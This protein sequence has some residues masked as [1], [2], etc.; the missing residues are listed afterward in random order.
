[1][2]V[3]LERAL[4]R[5]AAKKGLSKERKDAYVYGTLRKTGWKPER[6]KKMNDP[7]ETIQFQ[8]GK[9]Y[10][11]W[12][13]PIG[14]SMPSTAE[15]VQA[16]ERPKVPFWKR[17]LGLKSASLAHVRLPAP[18]KYESSAKLV[19][20]SLI[21]TALD[22]VIKF[23][24]EDDQDQRR[25]FPWLTAGAAA[26][27]GAG[28]LLAHQAIRSS[29]GYAKN[30]LGARAG[31]GLARSGLGA[32][33]SAG[34]SLG[35]KAGGLAGKGVNILG[36]ILKK[37]RRFESN[38]KPI[39]FKASIVGPWV[40]SKGHE[41]KI[42]QLEFPA[43]LSP[44]AALKFPLPKLMRYMNK[45]NLMQQVFSRKQERLVELNSKLDEIQL[46]TA[47]GI[48]IGAGATLGAAGA[49]YGGYKAVSVLKEH[50]RKMR[51]W[52]KNAGDEDF[53]PLA[54]DLVID[55][56][57]AMYPTDHP[58]VQG[59]NI[60]ALKSRLKEIQFRED[61]S[62][63]TWKGAAEVGGAAA[64]GYGGYRGIKALQPTARFIE[65]KSAARTAVEREVTKM[66]KR[67]GPIRWG[68]TG[69]LYKRAG[70]AFY[71]GARHARL[72]AK[73]DDV[74]QLSVR[75]SHVGE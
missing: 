59:G 55:R 11:P 64:V 30:L 44:A 58:R 1:M 72:S 6:E 60:T 31:Y 32:A 73:L 65:G 69:Q 40:G 5:Q 48:A 3:K 52:K 57:G 62:G 13:R 41:S 20:L 43:G 53:L 75:K 7:S 10:K 17:A 54:K 16:I 36:D 39:E 35:Y 70:T 33:S 26:G 14:Q 2:P 68:E 19:R 22:S 37:F 42:D 15:M 67:S 8:L 71:K 28:G 74:I 61:R 34:S 49:G 12:V 9:P 46:G 25:R 4:K 63:K 56:H 21:D 38:E 66:A 45:R 50:N 23:Q 24:Y 18:L 47:K 51:S 29:G 27:A